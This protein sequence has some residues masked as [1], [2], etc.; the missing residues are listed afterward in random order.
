MAYSH[1]VFVSLT[2]EYIFITRQLCVTCM[3]AYKCKR[4]YKCMHAYSFPWV[5]AL[6]CVCIRNNIIQQHESDLY[7]KIRAV[8]C[9]FMSLW[10]VITTLR[11]SQKCHTCFFDVKT[12]TILA[13]TALGMQWLMKKITSH[14]SIYIYIYICIENAYIHTYIYTHTYTDTY[15]C[16][17][18]Y[19][20]TRMYV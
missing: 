6:I 1:T 12:V 2:R 16:T 3:H 15:T 13:T 9:K 18:A 4:A 10:S 7:S 17:Y 19:I 11:T 8:R 5:Y 14:K 20:Y